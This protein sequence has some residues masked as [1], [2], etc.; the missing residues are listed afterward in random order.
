MTL[1]RNAVSRRTLLAAAG[2]A[3][4]A[5]PATLRAQGAYPERPLTILV[6][7]A[8]GGYNDRYAR[9]IAPFLQKHFGQPVVVQNRPGGSTMLGNMFYLQQPDDGYMVM[10]HSAGPFIPLSI[11]TRNAQY[12]ADDFWMINLPSR[13]ST[14]LACATNKPF[15]TVE[16]VIAQLK[17]DPRSIS[18]G[19]Q[20]A[21]ADLVNLALLMQGHGIDRSRMRIVTYDGGGPARTA[22]MGGH[23]DVGFVG[24]EGFLPVKDRIRPL[25]AFAD[26]KVD[27]FEETP[28]ITDHAKAAGF[29]DEF[30]DGSQRGFVVSKKFR[31]AAPER[32]RIMAQA[33]ERATKDPECVTTLKGQQ[34]AT[35]WYGPE[36]SNQAY[37]R[38]A[39]LMEK[40]SDLLKQA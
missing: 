11:L 4:L 35:T 27:G 31:D 36:A 7:F 37:L 24:G 8:T 2:G 10:V 30:V 32:Y 9:A 17:R 3:A 15:N 6:P 14:L 25:L 33:I 5:A 23:V 29:A 21:S 39:S 18:V 22:T 26:E 40:Y 19:V 12:K 16:E 38:S 1:R 28:L 13:D 20:P 34:L